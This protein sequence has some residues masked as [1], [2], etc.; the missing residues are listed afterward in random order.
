LRRKDGRMDDWKNAFFHWSLD[1]LKG[2]QAAA[3]SVA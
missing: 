1:I 3:R 2:F